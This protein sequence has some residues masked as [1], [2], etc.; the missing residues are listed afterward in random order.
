MEQYIYYA[1]ERG[2]WWANQYPYLYDD[3]L[4]IALLALVECMTNPA[5]LIRTPKGYISRCVDN[6]IITFLRKIGKLPTV[7][8]IDEDGDEDRRR[9]RQF[10]PWRRMQADEVRELLKLSEY[11]LRILVLREHGHTLEEIGQQ[12]GRRKSSICDALNGIG[13]RYIQLRQQHPTILRP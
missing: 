10:P 5:E 1:K 6:A 13:A 3:I 11:E 2:Y 7:R 9:P 8:L 12:I 4:A